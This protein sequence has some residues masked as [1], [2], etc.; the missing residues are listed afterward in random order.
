[1]ASPT[2]TKMT[3]SNVTALKVPAIT[4]P[5]AT[6][7]ERATQAAFLEKQMEQDSLASLRA[8]QR[9]IADAIKEAKARLPQQTPLERVIDRQQKLDQYIPKTLANRVWARVK[10][11]QPFDEAWSAVTEQALTLARAFYDGEPTDTDK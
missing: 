4:A 7:E 11:G 3:K 8:E 6:P 10:V 9:R 1:M 5:D 2:T